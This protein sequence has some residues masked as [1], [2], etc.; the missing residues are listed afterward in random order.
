MSALDGW[1]DIL[2]TGA[3]QDM[4][5]RTASFSE[6]DLDAIVAASATGDPVPVVVGHPEADA[7]AYGWVERMRRTGDRLQVRLRDIDDAFR[8]AVEAGRYSGRSVALVSDGDGAMRV[9]HLGFLGGRAPA[10]DGLAPTQFSGDAGTVR[11]FEL[12][13]EEMLRASFSV[14]ARTLRAIDETQDGRVR[15]QIH[16]GRNAIHRAVRRGGERPRYLRPADEDQRERPVGRKIPEQRAAVASDRPGP[17]AHGW[18]AGSFRHRVDRT[19]Q[20][21][22]L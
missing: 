20:L 1:F 3:W 7:P 17:Q 16:P 19:R 2:R 10:V 9:R 8:A 5:G 22:G 4:Q 15:I 11:T 21:L 18:L 12:A 14:I 6:S 13:S